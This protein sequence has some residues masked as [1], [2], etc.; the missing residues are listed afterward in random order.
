MRK[1]EKLLTEQEHELERAMKM[2]EIT[3][4]LDHM[5]SSDLLKINY[6]LGSGEWL[7]ILPG[8]PEGWDHLDEMEK[9]KYMNEISSYISH[10]LGLKTVL[11]Y[12]HKVGYGVSDTE[13]EDWWDSYSVR[14]LEEKGE[15]LY[16]RY[17]RRDNSR[18]SQ[19]P[20]FPFLSGLLLG[21]LIAAVAFCLI[22]RNY[23]G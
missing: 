8:K 23:L 10:H 15:E 2:L 1:E 20:S 18:D 13:F 21:F 7:D 22:V 6:H 19:K 11:R 9:A 14:L 17:C 3:D 16:E 5:S 4:Q 12:R